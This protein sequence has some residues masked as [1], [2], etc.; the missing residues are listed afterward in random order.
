[1][2]MAV[3]FLSLVLATLTEDIMRKFI[4]DDT[5]F[6]LDKNAVRGTLSAIVTF[7]G[8]YLMRLLGTTK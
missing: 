1:M 7:Y 4:E 8:V 2:G 3:G 6:S 5:Q